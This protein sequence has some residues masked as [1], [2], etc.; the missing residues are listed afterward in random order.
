MTGSITDRNFLLAALCALPKTV[1]PMTVTA[2][3]CYG[4]PSTSMKMIA[5]G[6]FGK[7]AMTFCTG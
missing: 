5:N 3:T 2:L 6:D 4:T 1:R 7:K